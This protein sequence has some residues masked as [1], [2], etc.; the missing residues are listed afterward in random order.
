MWPHQQS[1]SIDEFAA[2][3]ISCGSRGRSAYMLHISHSTSSYGRRQ[4]ADRCQFSHR[5]VCSSSHSL[6]VISGPPQF[7]V[8]ERQPTPDEVGGRD[9]ACQ[10]FK[11]KLNSM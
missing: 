1:S 11:F 7:D 2:V 6:G 3:D 10:I 8:P 5:L 4:C 9:A